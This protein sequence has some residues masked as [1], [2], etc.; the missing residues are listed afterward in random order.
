MTIRVK[1]TKPTERLATSGEELQ[2]CGLLPGAD[3]LGTE[4]VEKRHFCAGSDAQVG[5]LEALLLL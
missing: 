4:P 1:D 2:R 5:I 3:R